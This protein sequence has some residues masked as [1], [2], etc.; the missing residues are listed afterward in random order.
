M[1]IWAGLPGFDRSTPQRSRQDRASARL[2]ARRS[3]AQVL[4]ART[5]W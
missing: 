5:A 1:L 3:R 2:R 4:T